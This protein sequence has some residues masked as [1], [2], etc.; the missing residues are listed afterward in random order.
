MLRITALAYYTPRLTTSL[1]D[2]LDISRYQNVKP[3]WV[4]MQQK[5]MEVAVHR[6]K[7]QFL[8]FHVPIRHYPVKLLSDF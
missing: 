4:L 2:N 6:F 5:V 3:F 8:K 7:N 1:H